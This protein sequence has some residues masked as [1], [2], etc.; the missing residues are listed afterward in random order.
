MGPGPGL[1]P[2][3]AGWLAER[4]KKFELL[5]KLF[6][7]TFLFDSVAK[8]PGNFVTESPHIQSILWQHFL[9]ILPQ[10]PLPDHG[11]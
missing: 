8:K 11:G 5:L 1:W 3:L 7:P 6:S 4:Q 2:W 10:N 9:E